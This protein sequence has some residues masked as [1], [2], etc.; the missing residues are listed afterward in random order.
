MGFVTTRAQRRQL[1]RENAKQPTRMTPI[2]REQWPAT[3]PPGIVAVWRSHDFLA[4]LYGH[5]ALPR[6]S[7]SRTSIRGDRWVDGITW[8]ELQRVKSECGFGDV[9][10]VEVYPADRDVVNVGNLRHLW[11]MTVPLP[12]AWRAKDAEARRG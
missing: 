9:D 11:M 4:Q 1:E 7:V 12:F 2:P 5:E 3:T 10:A 8:D 6:L